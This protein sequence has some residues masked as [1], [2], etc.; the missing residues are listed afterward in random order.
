MAQYTSIIAGSPL[1]I[2]NNIDTFRYAVVSSELFLQQLMSESTWGNIELFTASGLGVFRV[3]VR[4]GHW[5]IDETL[6]GT[7][8]AGTENTSWKNIEKYKLS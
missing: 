4:S 3:G 7:G 8:F 6:D 2:T 1:T 5:V